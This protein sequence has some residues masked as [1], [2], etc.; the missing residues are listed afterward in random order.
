MQLQNRAEYD[1]VQFQIARI[2]FR[3]D[4]RDKQTKIRISPGYPR[5]GV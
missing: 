3:K 1:P 2:F 4:G 5:G